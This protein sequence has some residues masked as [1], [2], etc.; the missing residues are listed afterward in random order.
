[1]SGASQIEIAFKKAPDG[2]SVYDPASQLERK[3]ITASL[4][5]AGVTFSY[6]KR[7][8]AFDSAE[9]LLEIVVAASVAFRSLRPVIIEWIKGRTG[10]KVCI[11]A[12]KKSVEAPTIEEAKRAW[13]LIADSDRD[14]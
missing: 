11:R 14:A 6:P 8:M 10:Q 9:D 12:C 3:G 13:K 2:P 1:M 7:E 4:E 5:A